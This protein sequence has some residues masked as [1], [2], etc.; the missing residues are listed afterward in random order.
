MFEERAAKMTHLGK[1]TMQ[2]NHRV[3]PSSPRS[4]PVFQLYR[5]CS[6]KPGES[7]FYLA[8]VAPNTKETI[9]LSTQS[10]TI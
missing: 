1:K 5:E 7:K 2:Q 6:V 8:F 3:S 4:D 9:I 10:R